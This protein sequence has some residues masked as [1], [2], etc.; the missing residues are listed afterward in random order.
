MISFKVDAV[1][2]LCPIHCEPFVSRTGE[3]PRRVMWKNVK[4]W[5]TV[6]ECVLVVINHM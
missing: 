2:K 4:I 3:T 5:A 6:I 1:E